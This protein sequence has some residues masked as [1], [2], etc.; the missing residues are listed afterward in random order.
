MRQQVL[1]REKAMDVFALRNQLIKDYASYIQSFFKHRRRP[2]PAA[3]G[4]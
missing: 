3:C 4:A 2:D 1:F